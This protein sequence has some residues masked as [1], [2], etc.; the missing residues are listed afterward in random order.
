MAAFRKPAA[1]RCEP[2]L[3][4]RIR[5]APRANNP[6]ATVRT[7]PS[8]ASACSSNPA[9]KKPAPMPAVL[10]TRRPLSSEQVE[11]SLDVGAWNLELQQRQP[12]RAGRK[13]KS[14]A[15]KTT[16]SAH[17]SPPKSRPPTPHA[18]DG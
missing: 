11:A 5:C 8:P 2:V 15:E 14:S 1:G 3:D 17:P 16:C 10:R 12:P 13:P 6:E 4:L 9:Q 7:A 18:V